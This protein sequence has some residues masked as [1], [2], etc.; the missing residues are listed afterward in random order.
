M[1]SPRPLGSCI[2]KVTKCKSISLSQANIYQQRISM[3]Q[4][5]A[6]LIVFGGVRCFPNEVFMHFAFT[7]DSFTKLFVLWRS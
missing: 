3:A 7:E 4:A 2:L 1:A 5:S 6:P